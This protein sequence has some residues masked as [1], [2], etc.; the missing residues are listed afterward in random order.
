MRTLIRKAIEVLQ[1]CNLNVYL[2]VHDIELAKINEYTSTSAT[3]PANNFTI[4][5]AM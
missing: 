4:Q 1:L 5:K 3:D 2:V